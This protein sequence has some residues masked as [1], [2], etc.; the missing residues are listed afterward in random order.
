[1]K[2]QEN[3]WSKASGWTRLA[4]HGACPFWFWNGDLTPPE[5]LRQIRLMREQGIT[6]FI[7]HSRLGCSIPYLSDGWFERCRIAVEEAA[8]MG[9]KV[10]LYDEDNWPSGYAGGAVMAAEPGAGAKHICVERYYF[11]R[12]GTLRLKIDSPET[13]IAVHGVRIDAV[14]KIREH[15]LTASQA[16][17]EPPRCW[18]DRRF[19]EHVQPDAPST[20]LPLHGEEVRWDVPD[21]R[22]CVSV[23]RQKLTDFCPAY[24]KSRYVDLLNPA[25]TRAFIRLT[26][27]Q[28]A[29]HL[30]QYFGNTILG[31]FTD[32]PGFY[33]NFLDHDPGTVP[34][35]SDFQQYFHRRRGYDLLPWLGALWEDTGS[36]A[37]QVRADFWRTVGELFE[38]S[39]SR[40]LALWCEAHGLQLTGHLLIEESLL[41][42]QRFCANPFTVLRPLHV[43]GVDRIDEQ[44]VKI[45]EKLVASIGH[46]NGRARILSET[47]AL[48]GWKLAPPYMKRIVDHQ[49]VRGVNWLVPHAF[50]YSIDDWRKLECPP[51]LF[52]QNPWW[53]HS[54]A[55]WDHV[56][57]LSAILSQGQHVAPVALYYPIEH[58]WGTVRADFPGP[59]KG[60]YPAPYFPFETPAAEHPV[61]TTDAALNR[62]AST[63]L[64]AQYDFDLIDHELLAAAKI[65][66]SWLQIGDEAFRALVI[67]PIK[68]ICSRSMDMV[69]KF[70]NAGGHVIFVGELPE[71]LLDD[72]PPESWASVRASLVKLNQRDVVPFGQGDLGYVPD[73]EAGI[74]QLLTRRVRADLSVVASHDTR[75][76]FL[77]ETQHGQFRH[78]QLPKVSESLTYHR[79]RLPDG[80]SVYFVVNESDRTFQATLELAGGESVERWEPHTDRKESLACRSC[81]ERMVR[82]ALTF[83]PWQSHML[84]LGPGPHV[85]PAPT[86]LLWTRP[87]DG[88]TWEVAGTLHEG[89]LV[90]WHE[91]GLPTFSGVGTYHARVR[92]SAADRIDARI[93]L[94][95]GLVL[96]TARVHINGVELPPLAFPPYI[97]DLTSHLVSGDN[98]LRVDVANTLVNRFE[99]VERPSGMLG[100]VSL[101]A[102][103]ITPRSLR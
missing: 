78:T 49:Y 30:R 47:F 17:I 48:T 28:Y 59:T 21:G 52:F 68:A 29:K 1:M 65:D 67:P 53:D 43:T 19:F 31:F 73:G 14:R 8:R 15:P 76:R 72:D 99:K 54:K 66:R 81:G 3:G 61:E 57:G 87:I 37:V 40:E 96:E 62:I 82:V 2:F 22:W 94:D 7:I 23:F 79:R 74:I 25:T 83:E 97:A 46:A 27:E 55:F 92:L 102:T 10:W 85:A 101:R 100:P 36:R 50:Y 89:E 4:E 93:E 45:S 91:L 51:S 77:R 64:G 38:E 11:D 71:V 39:Y 63:L 35:T 84:V 42:M 86:E 20:L 44:D 26:H 98:E 32:E 88:W 75:Q 60:A 58:A 56:T 90:S 9:M 13:V 70:A 12:G 24:S 41:A 80:R 16:V 95:L 18:T 103:L 69:L 34:W 5:L 6:A 33:N